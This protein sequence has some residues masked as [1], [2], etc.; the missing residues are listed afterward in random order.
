MAYITPF[1]HILILF[2]EA[3]SFSSQNEL[4]LKKST[5]PK[6]RAQRVSNKHKGNAHSEKP[7][8]LD[9]DS[10]KKWLLE[11]YSLDEKRT[12]DDYSDE[13]RMKDDDLYEDDGPSDLS[14]DDDFPTY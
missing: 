6:L 8:M 14:E 7:R 12:L 10:D 2:H 5:V 4:C 1:F 11:D 9:D 13:K 3:V